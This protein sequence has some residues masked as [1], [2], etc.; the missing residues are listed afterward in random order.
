MWFPM[1]PPEEEGDDEDGLEVD[2]DVDEEEAVSEAVVRE[3]E[4]EAGVLETVWVTRPDLDWVV[5]FPVS[6]PMRRLEGIE[7][8]PVNV[9]VPPMLVNEAAARAS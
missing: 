4:A 8:A 9:S 7:L 3:A 5:G 1:N 2:V 6:V